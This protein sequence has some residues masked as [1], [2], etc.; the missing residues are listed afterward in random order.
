[1]FLDIFIQPSQN[2]KGRHFYL[3]DARSDQDYNIS[4]MIEIWVFEIMFKSVYR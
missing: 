4:L 3:P 1:M 2:H